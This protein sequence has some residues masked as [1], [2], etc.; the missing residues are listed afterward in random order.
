MDYTNNRKCPQKIKG[1]KE[2]EEEAGLQ[3]DFML[4]LQGARTF[5]RPMSRKE[6]QSKHTR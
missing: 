3:P 6:Q 4:Q 5:C 1:Q 2:E